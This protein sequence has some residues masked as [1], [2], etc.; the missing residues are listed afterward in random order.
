M[1]SW[2]STFYEGLLAR[3]VSESDVARIIVYVL[4]LCVVLFFGVVIIASTLVL[5][6]DWGDLSMIGASFLYVLGVVNYL[7][8]FAATSFMSG[9]RI[10]MNLR[11]RDVGHGDP[12][13]EAPVSKEAVPYR[14]IVPVF[15]LLV[16]L[17]VALIV[18][19]GF[20]SQTREIVFPAMAVLG[21]LAVFY[22]TLAGSG[23][24]RTFCTGGATN[25]WNVSGVFEDWGVMG[26]GSWC[27]SAGYI[28]RIRNPQGTCSYNTTTISNIE[29]NQK[30][31]NAIQSKPANGY[32]IR[33][34]NNIFYYIIVIMYASAWTGIRT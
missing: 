8:A 11:F 29:T 3:P 25:C 7:L 31:T 24:L 1:L 10:D 18:S 15:W 16:V 12:Y 19:V 20:F 33:E 13:R 4:H 5:Q 9:A 30:R 21:P 26:P 22:F 17:S 34:D 6:G 23:Y 28:F 14:W 27:I 32:S 2:R